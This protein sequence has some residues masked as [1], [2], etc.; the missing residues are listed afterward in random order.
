[1]EGHG[2]RHIVIDVGGAKGVQNWT[3]SHRQQERAQGCIGLADRTLPTDLALSTPT[4]I[5]YTETL[6][7]LQSTLM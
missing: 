1:M 2:F 4:T 6:N 7:P 5:L 3:L